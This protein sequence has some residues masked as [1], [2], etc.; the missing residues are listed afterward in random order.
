MGACGAAVV[1][2]EVAD[3][4]AFSTQVVHRDLKPANVLLGLPPHYTPKVFR[5]LPHVP[6]TAAL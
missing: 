6:Q 3:F 2:A 5:R 1:P 4:T